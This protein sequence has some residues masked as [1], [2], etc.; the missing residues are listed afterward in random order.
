MQFTY[1]SLDDYRILREDLFGAGERKVSDRD[2]VSYS[3][4]I[5]PPLSRIGLS[6]AEARKKGLNIKVNK[7][8]VV[9]IPRARTVGDTNGL[10]KVVVDADTDKIL[11]CTLFGPESSEVINLVAMAMKTG[12]EYTFLRDFVFTHP[13]MSEALNDLMGF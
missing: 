12:Q 2:P 5:D 6:E 3:V 9:A 13:S 1:I 11:G 4:F 8:P 7:L 10:F